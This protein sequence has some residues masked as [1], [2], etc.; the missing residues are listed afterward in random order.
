[1]PS[2]PRSGRLLP[3]RPGETPELDRGARDGRAGDSLGWQPAGGARTADHGQPRNGSSAVGDER[4]NGWSAAHDVP[5]TGWSGVGDEPRNG[6]SAAHD[7]PRNG[8]SAAHDEPRNGSSAVGDEYRNGWSAAYDA[9]RNGWSSRG[10]EARSG[11]PAAYDESRNGSGGYPA[12]DADRHGDT[13]GTSWW[14]SSSHTG[15]EGS[16]LLHPTAL[17][18]GS[19]SAG[20]DLDPVDPPIAEVS[21]QPWRSAEP[22]V[23]VRP[24]GP[25]SDGSDDWT[26]PLPV[27][28]PEPAA[29]PTPPSGFRPR[30]RPDPVDNPAA[31]YGAGSFG[32]DRGGAPGY[33][34]RPWS[35]A[36][37]GPSARSDAGYRYPDRP[38]PDHGFQPRVDH[39]PPRR[40]PTDGPRQARRAPERGTA[41]DRDWYGR[42]H[43]PDR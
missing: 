39:P 36:E 2:A 8:W 32:P 27:V 15:T 31:G 22:F 6:W 5:R 25:P 9:P 23:E 26:L 43:R 21:A 16:D 30:R 17:G 28:R 24:V 34:S 14:P 19:R 40:P 20:Y 11:W 10:D 38:D 4:R 12:P 13:A 18:T 35:G 29:P 37:Y 7:E 3:P 42:H 1:V 33:R 41:D